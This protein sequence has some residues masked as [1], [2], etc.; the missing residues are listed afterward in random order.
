[1]CGGGGDTCVRAAGARTCMFAC[2]FMSMWVL[3]LT[4]ML[5]LRSL[6]W[7]NKRERESSEVRFVLIGLWPVKKGL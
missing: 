5:P 2:A 6:V 4:W 1:M 3:F 7:R